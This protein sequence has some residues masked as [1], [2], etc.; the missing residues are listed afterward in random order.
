MPMAMI[1]QVHLLA[2]QNKIEEARRICENIMTQY[3][4]GPL[5]GEA[6][7]QLRLLGPGKTTTEPAAQALSP[8]MVVPPGAPIP[9]ATPPLT[10]PE[11]PT[12]QQP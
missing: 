10:K 11:N 6:A 5:A 1:S 12:P 4:E 7:R 9:A 8:A 2:E 3:R